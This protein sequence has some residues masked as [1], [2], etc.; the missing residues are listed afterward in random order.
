MRRMSSQIMTI[1]LKS[2][3]EN[4]FLTR[5]LIKERACNFPY[6]NPFEGRNLVSRGQPLP[7]DEG[8]VRSTDV[9]LFILEITGS[10]LM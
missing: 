8:R 6:W 5:A 1:K 7:L 3:L 10:W 2:C 4:Y 9:D